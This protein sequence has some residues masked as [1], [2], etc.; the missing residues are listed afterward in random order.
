MALITFKEDS[1]GPTLIL[2]TRCSSGSPSSSPPAAIRGV[3]GSLDGGALGAAHVAGL[4]SLLA[5]YD[6]EFH[7]LSVSHGADGLLGIVLE[8]G[9]LMDE[10]ILASVIPVDE[11]VAGLDVEPFDGTGDLRREGVENK[12][13][14]NT[15][16]SS[17]EKN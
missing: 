7:R 10:H 8:D 11:A 12:K 15:R 2:L 13:K 1:L 3:G 17:S 16:I 5:D 6:V 14:L 4:V 9:G